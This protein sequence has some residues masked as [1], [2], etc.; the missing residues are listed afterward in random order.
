MCNPGWLLLVVPLMSQDT[1]VTRLRK[2]ADSLAAEWRR[3]NALAAVADSLDLERAAAGRDTISVGALRIVANRSPLPLREAAERAWPVIDSLYGPL[4]RTLSSR[5]YFIRAFDPDTIARRSELR[6][7]FEIPWDLDV[8]RL[9]R[10]LL[11]NVPIESPDPALGEWLGGQIRPPL[12]TA[13]DRAH[14]YVRLV[15]APSGAARGCL[16]GDIRACQAALGLRD[17][18]DAFLLWYPS[19]AERRALLRQTFTE[20]FTNRGLSSVMWRACINGEDDSCTELLRSLPR[21]AIPRPLDQDARRL[22]VHL[23]L[24]TGGRE[25]YARLLSGADSARSLRDRLAA[26]AGVPAD[27]LVSRWRAAIIASRPIPVSLPRWAVLAA[28]GWTV[29]LAGFG[30]RSSRWRAV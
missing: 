10:F 7:G 29:L 11:A 15:T 18:V 5:P 12:R 14:V 8:E 4:A 23:A 24:Q 21:N 9:T 6:I 20:Y 28:I 26:A 17:S 22:L 13:Q 2:Q 16:L 30:L 19:S 3:A 25:A 27:T 1:L